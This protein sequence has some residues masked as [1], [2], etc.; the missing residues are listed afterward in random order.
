M[1][2]ALHRAALALGFEPLAGE[3]PLGEQAATG[4]RLYH[5]S[6]S[7][8]A[9]AA[10]V[11]WSRPP[12][13]ARLAAVRAGPGAWLLCAQACHAPSKLDSPADLASA[14][15]LHTMHVREPQLL[16]GDDPAWEAR[17]RANVAYHLFKE[18]LAVHSRSHA[19]LNTLSAAVGA[20]IA[21]FLDPHSKQ[22]LDRTCTAVQQWASE[23]RVAAV[24]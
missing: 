22:Q 3:P 8:F 7:A 6:E 23:L 16:L 9:A 18:D 11:H 24:P 15:V 12:L 17:F 4:P 19:N 1:E 13:F 21:D 5:L 14:G 10:G 2:S 20:R